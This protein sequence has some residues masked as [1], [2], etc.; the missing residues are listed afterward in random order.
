[1]FASLLQTLRLWRHEVRPTLALALPIMAGM[2]DK[3][4]PPAGPAAGQLVLRGLL[5][6]GGVEVKN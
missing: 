6:M 3:S 1:M 2:D 4:V 5:L